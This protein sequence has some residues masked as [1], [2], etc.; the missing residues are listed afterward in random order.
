MPDDDV[1][2]Q[3]DL[4]LEIGDDVGDEVVV[5]VREEGHGGDQR[6]TV[7]IDDLLQRTASHHSTLSYDLGLIGFS[8]AGQV[9][10]QQTP[11][12]ARLLTH[13]RN[14]NSS[15]AHLPAEFIP[16]Q[17]NILLITDGVDVKSHILMNAYH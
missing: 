12:I 4:E 17:Q 2:G 13:I 7:E 16:S 8:E 15:P 11:D 1:T 5:G 14:T 9:R 10:D 3:E 6:A